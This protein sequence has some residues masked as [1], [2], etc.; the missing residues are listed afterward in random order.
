MIIKSAGSGEYKIE[1][2]G[3][4]GV[5]NISINSSVVSIEGAP[6]K[7]DCAGE[8]EVK[9]VHVYAVGGSFLIDVCERIKIAYL[10]E[11]KSKLNEIMLEELSDADILITPLSSVHK[12]IIDQIEPY[13]LI[14]TNYSKDQDAKY[15][16]GVSPK[17]TN[18]LS[19]KSHTDLPEE[20]EVIV[21]R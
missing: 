16:S 1:S 5:V 14:P 10:A 12:E 6:F 21:L 4:N 9:G 20:M 8:Y 18:K 2:F 17:D 7:I 13:I 3:E 11:Q 15:F 19:L